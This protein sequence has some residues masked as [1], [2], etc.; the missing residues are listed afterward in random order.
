MVEEK[1]IEPHVPVWEKGERKDGMINYHAIQAD[2]LPCPLKEHC[3]P[4]MRARKVERSEHEAARDVAR[5]VAMYLGTGPPGVPEMAGQTPKNP[6]KQQNPGRAG[7]RT[8][9]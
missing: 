2:C 5:T 8:S 9:L 7:V 4:N 1:G 6:P 3:G